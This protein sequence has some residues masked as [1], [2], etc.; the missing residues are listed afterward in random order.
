[1]LSERELSAAIGS[2]AYGPDGEK[3]GTVEHFFTDDRTGAPTWMAVSTGLFGTRHSVVPAGD[4][5]FTEGS[6]RLPVTKE[7]VR[8]APPVSDQHL[9]PDDEALLRRHYGLDARPG[10]DAA[11]GP[12][13]GTTTVDDTVPAAAAPAAPSD[14][15]M[16]R[17]EEQLR[18]ATER[19]PARRVRVVKYVV[20]EE[21]T[22]TVPIRREEIRIEEVPLDA[23]APAAGTVDPAGTVAGA[24]LPAEIVLHAERPVVSTEVV[25]VERVRLRTELVQEQVQVSDQVRRERIDVD[26]DRVR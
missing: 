1:M 4:A 13:P 11:V 5:T 25:P 19:Y 17:S 9:E 26:Q 6:V 10:P 2:T 12:A 23:D 7:A 22:V 21:V 16:T 3:I 8:S 24:G 20:T 14:G 15:A 18:V